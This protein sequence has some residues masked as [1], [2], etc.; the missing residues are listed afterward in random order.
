MKKWNDLIIDFH[1]QLQLSELVLPDEIDVMNPYLGQDSTHV[2][3]LV[4]QFYRQYYQDTLE[5]HL[6]IGINPGRHGA[7]VTGI[8]FTDTKRLEEYCGIAAPHRSGRSRRGR[9][10]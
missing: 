6:I 8:P 10:P 3:A 1:Q 5:R 4:E 7:G 2:M 9:P